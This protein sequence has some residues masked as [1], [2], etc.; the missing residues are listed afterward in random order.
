MKSREFDFYPVAEN[1][2]IWFNDPEIN[3]YLYI[4]LPKTED[5]ILKWLMGYQRLRFLEY[6]EGK[7]FIA[8]DNFDEKNWFGLFFEERLV[9][10]LSC[11]KSV[12]QRNEAE[13][14]V[15]IFEL[16]IVIGE[17]R[18]WGRGLA[19]IFLSQIM[20]SVAQFGNSIL[21][22]FIHNENK[23]SQKLFSNLGFLGTGLAHPDYGEFGRWEKI[24]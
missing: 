13:D 24:L 4:I 21:L 12:L 15:S 23:S 6:G 14:V 9:G 3:R 2:L 17:K 5:E 8:I 16:G 1:Y 10:H 20:D 19:K 7:K 22:A 11:A 18:Y